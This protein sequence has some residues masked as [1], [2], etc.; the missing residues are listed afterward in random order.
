MASGQFGG[1]GSFLTAPVRALFGTLDLMGVVWG[2]VL[3]YPWLGLLGNVKAQQMTGQ[4][5]ARRA[6]N[7]GVGVSSTHVCSFGA[8]MLS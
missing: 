7:K 1:G 6:S 4:A 8:W 5:V 3:R 2:K